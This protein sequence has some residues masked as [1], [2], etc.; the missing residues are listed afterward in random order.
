[1]MEKLERSQWHFDLIA[2]V[3]RFQT[4]PLPFVECPKGKISLQPTS[5]DGISNQ[6]AT[7]HG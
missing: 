2:P 5:G 3:F 4:I 6:A 1:M 7:R